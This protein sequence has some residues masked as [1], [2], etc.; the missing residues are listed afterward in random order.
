MIDKIIKLL[1]NI[2]HDKLLHSFYGSLIYIC[3][4]FIDS[5]F[6]L[7]L[8]I[9]IAITKELYDRYSYG[10]FDYKDIVATMMM[11]IVLYI[12]EIYN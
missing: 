5:S 4:S 2:P 1:S 6:A 8:V 9:L 12:R 10:K 3:V 7:T 11:P